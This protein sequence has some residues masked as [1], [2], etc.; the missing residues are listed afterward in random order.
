MLRSRVLAVECFL[1]AGLKLGVGEA[2]VLV[3][4]V[5]DFE[6]A[7]QRRNPARVVPT[8]PLFQAVQNAGPV[9]ITAAGRIH[10]VIDRCRGY[11][12]NISLTINEGA[13]ATAGDN[14]S[15]HP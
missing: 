10:R 9:G 4:V 8:P 14:Q 5:L 12:D 13:L 3:A 11:F 7:Y 2:V 15:F 1:I 6:G